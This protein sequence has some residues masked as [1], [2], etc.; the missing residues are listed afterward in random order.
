MSGIV[1]DGVFDGGDLDCGSGLVLLIRENMQT[2]TVGQILEMRSREPT[3]ADDL[4]PW[5][6]MSGHE[7]LGVTSG[8]DCQRYFVKK[9]SPP[10]EVEDN[11][12]DDKSRAREYEWRVRALVPGHLHSKVYC[13][14][15]SIDVGQPASFEERDTHP[16]AVEYLLAALAG[17]LSVGFAS[18]VARYGVEVDD[19]EL[20]ARGRLNNVLAHLAMEE[21]DPSFASIELKAYVSTM[22]D[23][24]RVRQAWEETVARSPIAQTLGKSVELNIK[25]L[26]V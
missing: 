8:A 23:E 25:F 18:T 9:G 1:P 7:F 5:C 26:L 14:N 11:L 12:E 15:F 3:V 24:D 17:D 22:D 10:A 6:R 2:L 16:S 21:G 19:I 13:R 4:P 20:T